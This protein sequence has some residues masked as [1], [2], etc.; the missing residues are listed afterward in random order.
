MEANITNISQIN[1]SYSYGCNEK[2]V[3]AQ[4]YI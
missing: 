1:V 4:I 2:K 3:R